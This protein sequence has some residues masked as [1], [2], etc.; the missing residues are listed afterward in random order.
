[1]HVDKFDKALSVIRK[2]QIKSAVLANLL[3]ISR[4]CFNEKLNG[5][6]YSKFTDSQKVIILNYLK[7]LQKDLSNINL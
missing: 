2:H 6:R 1:M 5:T 4:G 3:N 7:L